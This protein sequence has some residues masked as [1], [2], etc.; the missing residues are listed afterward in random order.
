MKRYILLL[1]ATFTIA[2]LSAQ[3]PKRR[4]EDA[5]R[6]A[7]TRNAPTGVSYRDFPTAQAMPQDVAWRRDLY[8]VLN[9]KK[10]ANAVLYYPTT[11]QDG[12]VNLFTYLFHLLYLEE[13]L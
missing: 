6:S 11:P 1:I 13:K 9:L 2:T 8:R 3:P 7:A 5:A 12:R 10:D 4:A